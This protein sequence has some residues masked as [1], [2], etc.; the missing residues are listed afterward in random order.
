MNNALCLIQKLSILIV[1]FLLAASSVSIA[2]QTSTNTDS[3]S[4]AKADITFD[5]LNQNQDASYY[6]KL[7]DDQVFKIQILNTLPDKFQYEI[8]GV[9][10]PVEDKSI[11]KNADATKP[12]TK[13]IVHRHEKKYGGYILRIRSISGSPVKIDGTKMQLQDRTLIIVV[14]TLGWDYEIAGAFTI[15]WLTDPVFAL[16]QV[17][18]DNS[19][20]YIIIENTGARDQAKLGLGAFVHLFNRQFPLLAISF[21]LG[22][23]N[24]NNVTYYTGGSWR[25][26]GQAAITTGIAW[27]SVARLPNGLSIGDLTTDAGILNNLGKRTDCKFFFS[28]SLNFIK[29]A[30]LL[31]KPFAGA[32]KK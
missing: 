23:N 12:V 7:H 27:G 28:I 21:G 11:K 8:A 18:L 31:Q 2:E 9:L 29:A 32:E 19:N 26:G 16:K 17:E 13:E 3:T 22:V 15:N 20:K 1:L 6:L 4:A 14:E 25:L 24:D 5:H 10:L 30:D